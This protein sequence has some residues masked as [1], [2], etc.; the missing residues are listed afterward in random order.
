MGAIIGLASVLLSKGSCHPL[1]GPGFQKSKGYAKGQ[2]VTRIR[3]VG[4][5][6]TL[7]SRLLEFILG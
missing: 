2:R 4:N 6:Q 7:H 3:R 5:I 1:L